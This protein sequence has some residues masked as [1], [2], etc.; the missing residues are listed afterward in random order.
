MAMKYKMVVVPKEESNQNNF[1][2]H[3]KLLELMLSMK[4]IQLFYLKHR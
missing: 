4:C 3:K 1:S 2:P